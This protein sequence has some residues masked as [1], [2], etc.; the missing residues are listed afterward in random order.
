MANSEESIWSKEDGRSEWRLGL[1]F[2]TIPYVIGSV[3]GFLRKEV[4]YIDLA[5]KKITGPRMKD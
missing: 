5:F 4:P 3:G 2:L 1:K